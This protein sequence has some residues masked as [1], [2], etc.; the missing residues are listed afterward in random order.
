MVYMHTQIKKEAIF[1]IRSLFKN[2][3]YILSVRV[4]IGPLGIAYS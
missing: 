3:F 1:A 2:Y 4:G